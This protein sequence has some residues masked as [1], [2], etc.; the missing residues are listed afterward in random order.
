M[1]YYQRDCIP[2]FDWKEFDLGPLLG[3]G[4][5]SDVYEIKTFCL[6]NNR[7]QDWNANEEAKRLGMQSCHTYKGTQTARYALKH[8]KPKSHNLKSHEGKLKYFEYAR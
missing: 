7:Y 5:F 6:E 3:S 8:I 2:L 4:E 1:E